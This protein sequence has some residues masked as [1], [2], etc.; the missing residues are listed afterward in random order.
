MAVS[1]V[2]V[3]FLI[4]YLQGKR[5]S[6]KQLLPKIPFILLAIATGYY[7]VVVQ[8]KEAINEFNTFTLLQRFMFAAYGFVLYMAKIFVPYYLSAFY[9]YPNVNDLGNI[10]SFFYFAPFVAIAIVTI[11][12]F[13]IYR[14][15]RIHLPVVIFGFAFYFFTIALVLQFISVG[16][17]IM[18]ERYSYVPYIGIM[19]AVAYG[20]NSYFSG[21]KNVILIIGVATSLSL[22]YLCYNRVQVW[23]NN[24]TLWTDVIEK[25]PHRIEVAYKNRGNYYAQ[26]GK[27]DKAYEDH[28]VLMNM[29][30]RDAGVYTNFANLCGL[31]RNFDKALEAYT[32]A[33]ELKKSDNYDIYLN[34]AITYSMMKQY[35]KALTDFEVADK[36]KPDDEKLYM[37]RAYVYLTVGMYEKSI[38]DY[39]FLVKRFP[40]DK[41]HYFNRGLAKFNLKRFEDATQDF[42]EAVKLDP[43]YKEAYFNLS[44]S[45]NQL[46]KYKEALAYAQKAK[47]LGHSINDSYFK[48]IE[49]K[50]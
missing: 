44:V 25:Y 9:P 39:D 40:D 1:L 27:L 14:F 11:P 30:T 24:E 47:S 12:V 2:P 7:A 13:L 6:I 21:K 41:M 37:N 31:R 26:A 23:K 36:M 45:Y 50:M 38:F 19:Y 48:E 3:L 4:D 35:D 22:A 34:R 18:A 43:A 42:T 17:A 49:A 10:P 16:S 8:S 33:L 46:G 15:R 5:F 32:H 28:I 29:K 20:L